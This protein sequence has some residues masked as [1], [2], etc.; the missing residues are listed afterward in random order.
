MKTIACTEW[1]HNMLY[2]VA[3]LKGDGK[4]NN[5]CDWGYTEDSNKAIHLSPYWQK[6]FRADC[7]FCGR[8]AVFI[9]IA[10]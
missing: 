2:Y 7:R 4:R 6:R 9:D 3:Q 10:S 5:P 1:K 8:S